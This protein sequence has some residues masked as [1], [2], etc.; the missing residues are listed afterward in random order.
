M[1]ATRNL[2]FLLAAILQAAT[3]L[4]RAEEIAIGRFGKA[5][6]GEWKATGTAFQKGPPF[7]PNRFIANRYVRS[8]TSPRDSGR[9]TGSIPA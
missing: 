1:Q 8:S 3:F 4:C 5:D 9:W 7:P 2:G 6:Y